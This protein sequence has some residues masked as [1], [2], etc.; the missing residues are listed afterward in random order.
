MFVISVEKLTRGRKNTNCTKNNVDNNCIACDSDGDFVFVDEDG[1]YTTA[2]ASNNVNAQI[3]A[4]PF[5][6]IDPENFVVSTDENH[7]IYPH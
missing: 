4:V 2:S 1:T 7:L 3:R 6:T 5:D